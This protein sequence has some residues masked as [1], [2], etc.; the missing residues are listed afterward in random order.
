[1]TE[2]VIALN[3]PHFEAYLRSRLRHTPDDPDLRCLLWRQLE[4]RGARLEAAQV[5]EHLAVTPCRQLTLDDRLDFAARAVVAVKALPPVQQDLDY[6]RELEARLELAQLQQQLCV[7]LS[8]LTPEMQRSSRV[9]PPRTRT[10]PALASASSVEEAVSQLSHGPLLSLTEMFTNYADP[11]GLHESKLCLLWASGSTD[12]LLIKAIWR[13]LLRQ[14]LSQSRTGADLGTSFNYMSPRSPVSRHSPIGAFP[15][16]SPDRQSKQLIE[17][18]LVDCLTRLGQRFV[19]ESGG[20]GSS[21]AQMFF[22][23]TEIV[24]TLEYFAVQKKFPVHWVPTILR[25][26]RLLAGSYFVDAYDQLLHSKDSFWR[27]PEVRTRLFSAM[28]TVIEDFLTSGSVQ[29]AMRP[30]MLQ[31]G[32]MLDRVTSNLVDLNA[33]SLDQKTSGA[34]GKD[35]EDQTQVVDRLRRVHDQLQRYYR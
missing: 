14:V 2:T 7:E 18:S 28:V 32:R 19:T 20:F 3:S 16:Q 12:E 6:L 24:S 25:D 1:L 33:N 9:S 29:L 35:E 31:V 23:L 22:P 15:S 4:H 34:Q 5:L 11:F 8:Q 27:R 21:R 17:L 13:D 26:T 10:S 30:R